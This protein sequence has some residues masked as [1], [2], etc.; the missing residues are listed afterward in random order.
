MIGKMLKISFVAA[1]VLLVIMAISLM[2]LDYL[3]AE[4]IKKERNNVVLDEYGVGVEYIDFDGYEEKMVFEG[5]LDDV[6]SGTEVAKCIKDGGGFEISI[7]KPI[8][9][10]AMNEALEENGYHYIM[11]NQIG[12]AI[13]KNDFYNQFGGFSAIL[14]YEPDIS[15][16]IFVDKKPI[17]TEGLGNHQLNFCYEPDQNDGVLVYYTPGM[18]TPLDKEIAIKDE[19]KAILQMSR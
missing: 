3:E 2:A 15:I 7:S 17:A 6:I 10:S 12:G 9:S 1:L 11:I 18:A 13:E 16:R 5:N 19:E 14:F 8:L 4:K